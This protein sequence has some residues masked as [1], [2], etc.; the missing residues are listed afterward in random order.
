MKRSRFLYAIIIVVVLLNIMA[1]SSKAEC[2]YQYE[3]EAWQLYRLGLFAG[4]S[5]HTFKPD[6]GAPLTRQIGV[7]LLLNF[8]GKKAEVE[9]MTPSEVSQFLSKYKDQAEI[10]QWARPY[11]AY[12]VKTGVV[13]GTSID[14]ISPNNVLDGC[15]FVA[16][17]LRQLGY[18]VDRANFPRSLELLSKTGGISIS[19]AELFNK[20]HLI[21]NDGIG[22][23]YTV[24]FANCAD[25]LT[26][27][28]KFI[29]SGYIPVDKAVAYKLVSYTGPESIEV[30]PGRP[31][32][33]DQVYYEIYEALADY[34]THIKLP[35]T[36]YT[37]SPQKVFRLIELCL[38]ENPDLLYYSGCIYFSD[39][40]V[41]LQYRKDPS[42]GI[43]HRNALRQK[44]GEIV[45]N[46]VTPGM[47]DY[48]KELVLHDYLVGNCKYDRSVYDMSDVPWESFSAY[49][50]LCLGTAVCEGYAKAMKLLLNRAGIECHI[51]TGESNGE[52]HAW[53][54]VKIDGETYHLDATYND[55]VLPD[56][57][58]TAR[59]HYFNLTDN[60][61]EI[62]HKWDKTLYPSCNSTRYNFYVYNSLTVSDTNE[63]IR[64]AMEEVNAG[65]TKLT[66]RIEN[67]ENF[68]YLSVAREVCNRLQ[69]SCSV[70]YNNELGIVDLN[71]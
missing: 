67:P 47:T 28:E 62:D 49:G 26:V 21:K 6:L 24:L 17:V 25:G 48:E 59:Y 27:I 50:A 32:L 19:E 34:E 22:I 71:F 11:M 12:A 4:A 23:M 68:D 60:E 29:N 46:V 8:F 69:R 13:V 38:L 58:D 39:G 35:E 37:D 2:V 20:T 52:N 36:Q 10:A 63:L 53:N 64:R 1:P 18:T 16:L 70:A 9:A 55:P 56:G 61:M 42:D 30:T 5:A 51:V 3:P 57:K 33:Y 45:R 44:I 66:F 40:T 14:T 43:R 41:K 31:D 54:I 65:N 7:T 15:S